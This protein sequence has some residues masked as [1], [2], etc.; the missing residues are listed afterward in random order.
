MSHIPRAAAFWLLCRR[1]GHPHRLAG[2]EGARRPSHFRFSCLP[3]RG[4]LIRPHR[5]AE[6]RF[7][8]G[9]L[10][11]L[12]ENRKNDGFPL[13]ALYHITNPSGAQEDFRPLPMG[14]KGEE[15]PA[16]HVFPY[17][18]GLSPGCVRRPGQNRL[19]DKAGSRARAGP[20]IAGPPG[21][22]ASNPPT[23]A[24]APPP[25]PGAWGCGWRPG[26]RLAGGAL[27]YSP[28]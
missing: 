2:V 13:S 27:I 14:R 21:P 3:Q 1:V 22:S 20:F 24:G 12:V 15:I 17:P 6:G 9:R 4:R 28:L 11:G 10:K 5:P 8:H 23:A 19:T 16:P 25:S 26:E 7:A 18:P